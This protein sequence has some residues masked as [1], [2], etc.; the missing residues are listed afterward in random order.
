MK[1]LK[2]T[3]IQDIILGIAVLKVASPHAMIMLLPDVLTCDMILVYQYNMCFSY[4][5]LFMH[6]SIMVFWYIVTVQLNEAW[7][8]IGRLLIIDSLKFLCSL[9]SLTNC[10]MNWI[11]STVF[12]PSV[13]A[14]TSK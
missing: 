7:L 13:G 8:I 9:P 1:I 10:Q 3:R 2:I 6:D 11:N 14:Q 5:H 4:V 12:I